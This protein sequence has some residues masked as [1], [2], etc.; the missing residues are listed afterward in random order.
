MI[1]IYNIQYKTLPLATYSSCHQ[2]DLLHTRAL[3]IILLL[4]HCESDM[5]NSVRTATHGP[6]QFVNEPF[7]AICEHTE[8][9]RGQGNGK[10][11]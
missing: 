10:K 1:F 8:P 7:S 5:M 11:R 3:R 6:V 2:T 9:L 4:A